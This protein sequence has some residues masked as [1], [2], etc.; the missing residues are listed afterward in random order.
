MTTC[1]VALGS[2]LEDP[3]RQLR[4]ATVA[5]GQLPGTRLLAASRIVRSVAVGPGEQPDY[6]NAVARLDTRLAPMALLDYLQAIEARQGR[7]R[8]ERWGARTLDLDLLL[9]G[10]ESL[11]TE[12][13]TLPHPR[14]CERN[15]VLYPL[16][17]VAE[18]NL[19]L[20]DGRKLDT[21]IRA[22]PGAA[23]ASIDEPLGSSDGSR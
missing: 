8:T 18:A 4:A 17:D 20:P 15:F 12:R 5:L 10:D 22:C 14:M 6:L 3:L 21:L 7:I 2:N 1:Y 16:R 11:D 23:P 13:L 9:Y 19:M